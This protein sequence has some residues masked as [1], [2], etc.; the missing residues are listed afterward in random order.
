[1]IFDLFKK[2][3]RKEDFLEICNL[4]GRYRDQIHNTTYHTWGQN[5]FEGTMSETIGAIVTGLKGHGQTGQARGNK[6]AGEE[7]RG[8]YKSRIRQF[9]EKIALDDRW[10]KK[11][12]EK[13][14]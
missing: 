1:M 5:S 3:S 12:L 10:E 6:R 13:L 4:V 7:H 2:K 14:N 11:Y 8:D 9:I